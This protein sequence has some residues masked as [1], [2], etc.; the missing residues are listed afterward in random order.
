METQPPFYVVIRAMQ[1]ST[2][3]QGK[4]VAVMFQL[5]LDPEY[6]LAPGKE[7]VTSR[8]SSAVKHSID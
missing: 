5:F 6:C 7:P 4:G 1:R 3:L 2:R 8:P